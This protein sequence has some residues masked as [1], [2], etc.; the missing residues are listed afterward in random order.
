ML[1]Q[2]PTDP[3]LTHFR[4]AIDETYR[5]RLDRSSTVSGILFWDDQVLE[6]LRGRFL[7]AEL[8]M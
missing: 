7:V 6:R 2:A 1:K 4:A 5:E 3:V 8:K